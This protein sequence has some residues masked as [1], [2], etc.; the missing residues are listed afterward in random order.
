MT[1]HLHPEPFFMLRIKPIRLCSVYLLGFIEAW[2][3]VYLF[4]AILFNSFSVCFAVCLVDFKT[5]LCLETLIICF[6]LLV[7]Q[8][9]IENNLFVLSL[10][11]TNSR[12]ST[13]FCIFHI[14]R[15]FHQ[16]NHSASSNELAAAA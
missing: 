12:C 14:A 15:W 3:R 6:A 5:H 2:T 13:A 11:I 10:K 7:C 1:C 16:F 4:Q 8:Q 9:H